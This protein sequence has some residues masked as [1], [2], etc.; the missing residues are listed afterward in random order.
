[1]R[2]DRDVPGVETGPVAAILGVN[3]STADAEKNDQT[4][5]KDLGFAARAGW[6]RIIKA[7]L[8]AFCAKDVR[9][10]AKAAYPVGAGNDAYL[11]AIM[12]EA[13]IVVAAWGPTAKLPR[14]LRQRWRAV[15]ALAAQAGKPLWCWGTAKDGQPR[16]PLTLAYATPLVP[17]SPPL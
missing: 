16:H 12:R 6:S 4:I 8:F 14:H 15:V 2:L 1:M 11:L 7:N 10:V 3:P 17:W 5:R 9:D 13:D